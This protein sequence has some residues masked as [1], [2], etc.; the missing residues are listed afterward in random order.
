[1]LGLFA[2]HVLTVNAKIVHNKAEAESDK[3][4]CVAEQAGCVAWGCSQALLTDTDAS[5]GF[6]ECS[7]RSQC[8]EVAKC[9]IWLTTIQYIRVQHA[10][11]WLVFCSFGSFFG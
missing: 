2:A 7:D 11:L 6:Y 3:P 10:L 1:M 9:Q 5:H 4:G 8:L